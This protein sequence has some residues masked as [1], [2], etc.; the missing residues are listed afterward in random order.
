MKNN[1]EF[2]KFDAAMSTILKADPKA[3]KAA[4]EQDKK[5][6]AKQRKPKTYSASRASIGKD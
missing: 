5:D 2:D 6:R 3:V 1:P 4:M